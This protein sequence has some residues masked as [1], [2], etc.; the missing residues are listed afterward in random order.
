MICEYT[1]EEKKRIQL[2][3]Y[4]VQKPYVI[5]FDEPLIIA[6]MNI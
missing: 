4:L 1:F 5:M 3:A 6:V 2:A